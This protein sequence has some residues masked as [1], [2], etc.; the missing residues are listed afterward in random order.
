MP[1]SRAHGSQTGWLCRLSEWRSHVFGKSHRAR[2]AWGFIGQDWSM[3]APAAGPPLANRRAPASHVSCQYTNKVNG[4][5]RQKTASQRDDGGKVGSWRG[6]AYACMAAAPS[7]LWYQAGGT[8]SVMARSPQVCWPALGIKARKVQAGRG[9]HGEGSGRGG[10]EEAGP[11]GRG[12]LQGEGAARPSVAALCSFQVR[13]CSYRDGRAYAK[14]RLTH[15]HVSPASDG[16]SL[17]G[18][19]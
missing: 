11:A 2:C 19:N 14:I 12:V 1:T 7:Y 9:G 4:C 8:S 18:T 13:V 17:G 3:A 15:P 10:Q 16:M 5:A 6:G